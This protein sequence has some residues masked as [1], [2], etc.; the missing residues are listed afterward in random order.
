MAAR[1]SLREMVLRATILLLGAL[2]L[3]IGGTFT[4]ITAPHLQRISLTLL[5]AIVLAWLFVLWRTRP[6]RPGAPFGTLYATWGAVFALSLIAS[7]SGRSVIALWYMGLYAAVWLLLSHLRQR[8]LP[9]TAFSDVLIIAALPLIYWALIQ[10][11]PWFPRWWAVRDLG[12]PMFPARPVGTF[13]NSNLL[14]AFLALTLPFGLARGLT[15]PDRVG[16]GLMVVWLGLAL[17]TLYLTYSRGAWLGA[18]SGLA[19]F[20]ALAAGAPAVRG[21]PRAFGWWRRSRMVRGAALAGMVLGV[22]ALAIGARLAWRAF[23]S[24]QRE[25]GARL[26]YYALA[27]D[28]LSEHPL[29]GTGL[30][31]FG[32]ELAAAGSI[33]PEQPHAHAHNLILNIGAELGAPGL[34][35]VAVTVIVIAQVLRRG[36]AAAETRSARFQV[37]AGAGSLAAIGAHSLVDMPL[38]APSLVLA[39][40]LALAAGIVPLESQ[41][42]FSWQG[43]AVIRVVTTTLWAAVVLTGWKAML[44]NERYTRGL[45]AMTDGSLTDALPDLRAAADAQPWNTQYRAEY[46]YAAGLAAG[47]GDR[48]A[49]D[50]AATAYRRAL[51]REPQ[52]ALWWANLAAVEWERGERV[53]A[54]DAMQRAVGAAPEAADLWLNL[55]LYSEAL[56]DPLTAQHAYSRALRLAPRM[57]R[58]GFWRETPLRRVMLARTSDAAFPENMA[59]RLWLAGEENAAIALLRRTITR[60]PTQPRPFIEVARRAL[61][62]GQFD[63]AERYLDA[64]DLLSPIGQ[65]AVWTALLRAE[66]AG[67]RGEAEQAEAWRGRAREA[68]A[69]DRTGHGVT[70]GQDTAQFQFLSLT[71]PGKLLPQLIVLGPEPAALDAA[72]AR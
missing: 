10:A 34:L 62:T 46:A 68:V 22:V 57:A 16:R 65:D 42:G 44:D 49:V 63:R 1:Q 8:G 53:S 70:Y 18:A 6:T 41:K 45:V 27:L 13:G 67:A 69:P 21:W 29:A 38:M 12:V 32:R 31:T 35:A 60:D 58:A 23:D 40:L 47:Q 72:L 48:A 7:F 9:A 39:M 5:S 61:E 54:L 19:I 51:E 55:G 66:V 17:A 50:E 59:R 20:G 28:L 52:H 64:A 43:R 11:L 56:G 37:A 14:G 36:L 71:V 24:P 30:F 3:L 15:L 26:G 4:G 2:A 25:T 33:P